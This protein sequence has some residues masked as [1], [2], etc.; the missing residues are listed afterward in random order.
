MRASEE[1]TVFHTSIDPNFK[2]SLFQN[3]NPSVAAT[4]L[5]SLTLLEK[6]KIWTSKRLAAVGV[7]VRMYK[8]GVI[9]HATAFIGGILLSLPILAPRTAHR[10]VTVVQLLTGPSMLASRSRS[11]PNV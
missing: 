10:V 7:H 4:D 9:Q 2:G 6:E 5:N 11:E 1:T 8:R 3:S